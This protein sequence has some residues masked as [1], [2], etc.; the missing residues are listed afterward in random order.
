VGTPVVD[1]YALTNL[2][3]APWQ[4]PHELLFHDVPCRNC[5]KSICPLE[6]HDCL[7]R[8]P[9]AA[10]VEAA[11]RLLAKSPRACAAATMAS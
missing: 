11:L 10:V 1:L 8:V 2:Q 3:H 5:Y 6:H 9:P 7:R 4:V